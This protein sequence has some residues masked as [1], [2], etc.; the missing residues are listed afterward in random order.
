VQ[1]CGR[2]APRLEQAATAGLAPHAAR[3]AAAGGPFETPALQLLLGMAHSSKRGRAEL[4][5][6]DALRLF[7]ALLDRPD[8]ALDATEALAAWLAAEAWRCEPALAD[9]GD[10]PA[11]ALVAV[12][13][14]HAAAPPATLL[15]L[16]DALARL[17]GRSG[18]LAGRLAAAGLLPLCLDA[19]RHADPAVRLGALQLL[20]ALYE[21]HPRPKELIAR[22]DLCAKLSA[23]AGGP[24]ETDA[25]LVRAAA[26]ALLDAMRINDLM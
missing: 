24:P 7:V 8:W 22:H 19:A 23:I 12:F 14:R 25:L 2:S 15:R 21:Q 16:T 26:A 3:L 11:A 9:Q 10:A 4:A 1:L 18:R 5:K 17:A 6:T 13:A 20:R